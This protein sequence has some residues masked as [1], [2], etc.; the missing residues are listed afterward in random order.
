MRPIGGLKSAEFIYTLN[1][2]SLINHGTSPL[3]NVTKSSGSILPCLT[4]LFF[5]SLLSTHAFANCGGGAVIDLRKT[6]S[7]I[8]QSL[9]IADQGKYGICYSH[10]GTTLIDFF[11]KKLNSDKAN[12]WHT[13]PVESAQAATV[14]ATNAD[15]EGGYICDVVN[16][17]VKRGYG[18]G[19]AGLN[20]R[21]VRDLGLAVQTQ[22]VN[23]I[24]IK[25]LTHEKNFKP[26]RY[27][28]KKQRGELSQYERSYLTDFDGFMGWLKTEVGTRGIDASMLPAEADIFEMLQINH[29]QNLYATF[30]ARFENFLSSGSCGSSAF[31]MPKLNCE[32][33]GRGRSDY[34]SKIDQTLE[35]EKNPVGIDV[36][37]TAFTKKNYKGIDFGSTKSDCGQHAV[38]VIGRKYDQGKCKYLIRNSWGY[39]YS[40]YIW[41]TDEGDFWIDEDALGRNIFGESIVHY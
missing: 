2:F 27:H 18:C 17:L 14:F 8:F 12:V 39:S 3:M 15:P 23:R 13:S 11:R 4:L 7:S 36:C 35:Y 38:L 29:A 33:L 41:N 6:H 1:L 31:T 22:A 30:P 37:A 20:G 32:K 21:Q 5:S 34:I 25:F 10:A 16:A 19:N 40:H 24:Y 28:S 9:P 26:I